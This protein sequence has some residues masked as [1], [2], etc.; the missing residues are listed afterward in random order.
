MSHILIA[1]YSIAFFLPGTQKVSEF[2]SKESC[3]VALF[4][5]KKRYATVEFESYCISVADLNLRQKLERDIESARQQLRK[6]K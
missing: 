3:E 2:S 1:T 6:L 5:E 4:L